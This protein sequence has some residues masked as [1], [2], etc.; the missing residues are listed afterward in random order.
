MHI[1]NK[2][3]SEITS[4]TLFCSARWQYIFVFAHNFEG[5]I[6]F[7]GL[8]L[9]RTAVGISAYRA[10]NIVWMVLL[11]RPPVCP[12]VWPT[13]SVCNVFTCININ[14][15]VLYAWR[16]WW[17]GCKQKWH[18]LLCML[19]LVTPL[20]MICIHSFSFFLPGTNVL[21]SFCYFSNS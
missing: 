2:L 16:L 17:A 10:I 6:K 1:N 5:D 18:M 9:I 14:P 11:A 21:V 12:S 8:P 13:K 20:A 3:W 4:C 7:P 15:F 19:L